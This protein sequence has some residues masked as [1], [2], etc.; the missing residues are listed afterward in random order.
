[1]I[2]MCHTIL[3]YKFFTNHVVHG[4]LLASRAIT[5]VRGREEE[6]IRLLSTLVGDKRMQRRHPSLIG[7][8]G[9]KRRDET[10]E[11]ADWSVQSIGNYRVC[12]VAAS[13]HRCGLTNE[14]LNRRWSQ[15]SPVL[16]PVIYHTKGLLD[17]SVRVL[18]KVPYV[19]C[20][21]HGHSRRKNVFLYGCSNQDSWLFSDRA[22]PDIPLDYL[23]R[24]EGM[25]YVEQV[26]PN[27]MQ[28]Y[29]V[30]FSLP[31]CKFGFERHKEATARVTVWREF[32]V[33]RS[34]TMECS[35]CGWD[36][37]MYK[38]TYNMDADLKRWIMPDFSDQ[39]NNARTRC[40]LNVP[41]TL[42]IHSQGNQLNTTHLKEVGGSL[43]AAIA[44]L[45]D[46]TQWRSQAAQ[47]TVQDNS[48][49]LTT[50]KEV[51]ELTITE[52]QEQSDSSSGTEEEE[53]S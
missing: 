30:G 17:Y 33:K 53:G 20:D 36:I 15:P 51:G 47:I 50:E 45:R 24:C 48:G 16:H 2:K 43:C 34:Y 37:G 27:I 29:S 3:V 6:E 35:F 11:A 7:I 1:M 49:L 8:D 44:C 39:C 22:Q 10:R 42:L 18:K 41:L 32:G 4:N 40:K 9:I 38:A 25:Q 19:F 31:L 26:L 21:I 46:E 28:N 14:D 52:S 13:P 23:V 5:V 12:I